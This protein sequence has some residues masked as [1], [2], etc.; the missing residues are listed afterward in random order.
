MKIVDFIKPSIL[1]V[2]L[3]LVLLF[4]SFLLLGP[5]FPLPIFQ[6]LMGA[7]G[8]IAPVIVP[9]LIVDIVFWYLVSCAFFYWRK[10]ANK[11][12]SQNTAVSKS[13]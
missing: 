7:S 6:M 9:N 5:G 1:S 12:A 10:N 11:K 3:T 13:N 8:S 2:V 4:I